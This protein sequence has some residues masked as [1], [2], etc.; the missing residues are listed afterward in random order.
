MPAPA[1]MPRHLVGL[2]PVSVHARGGHYMFI[3]DPERGT[4][5]VRVSADGELVED[6]EMRPFFD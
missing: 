2:H 6:G 5:R 1:P 3:D 4:I